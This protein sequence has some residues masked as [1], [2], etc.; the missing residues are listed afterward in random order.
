MIDMV[1]NAPKRKVTYYYGLK[2]QF[3]AQFD[4]KIAFSSLCTLIRSAV[5]SK[6]QFTLLASL[7]RL[8]RR[9]TAPV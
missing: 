8:I 4:K 9:S 1:K 2:N 5:W 7:L 6:H 3:T